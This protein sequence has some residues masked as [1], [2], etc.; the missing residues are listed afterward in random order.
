MRELKFYNYFI[1]ELTSTIYPFTMQ[2]MLP[3]TAIYIVTPFQT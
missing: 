3:I 2:L 1:S